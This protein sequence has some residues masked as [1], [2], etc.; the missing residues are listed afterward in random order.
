M[1]PFS[2][3][4]FR[5]GLLLVCWLV[6]GV[7]APVRAQFGGIDLI[8]S[9]FGWKAWKGTNEPVPAAPDWRLVDYD[10]FEWV[11]L[12]MPVGLDT[13]TVP[14]N[15]TLRDMRGKYT[16]LF[17][18]RPFVLAPGVAFDALRLDGFVLGGCVVSVNG[19]DVHR[20]RVPP[21]P[22]ALSGV[23]LPPNPDGGEWG[24]INVPVRP[25]V[26]RPGTNV[27]AIRLVNAALD[28]SSLYCSLTLYGE[29]DQ[30]PPWVQR[31]VPE[32]DNLVP[33]L[34][35]IEVV[36]GEG[37]AGVRAGDLLVNGV[38]ATNV[39]E[40]SDADYVFSFPPVPPGRVTVTFREGHAITDRSSSSNAFRAPPA[41][42]YFVDPDFGEQTL[43]ITEF[44]ADNEKGLK[45]EDG[46]RED[47]VEVRNLGREALQL[48][49]W[50]LGTD[51]RGT[52][53][54]LFPRQ[55]LGAGDYL[56]VF[57]S[58][59]NRTNPVA[60][61]HTGFKVPKSGGSLFLFK[62]DG[63]VSSGFTNYPVQLAD[64]SYGLVPGLTGLAGYFVTPTPGKKN[65]EGG[66]GFS[67]EVEFSRVSGTHTGTVGLVLQTTDPGA[68]IRYTLDQSEP[69][70][71]SLSYT[72]PMVLTN[73]AIVRA[74]AFSPGLLPGPVRT[75]AFFPVS[76]NLGNWTSTLPV[77]VINDFDGGRPPLGIRIPAYVQVFEPG[78]NGVTRLLDA[79]VLASRAAVASRG[80]STAG[81]AKVNLRLEFQ[82]EVGEDRKLPFAGLPA[83]ADW[84]LYG[85]S[86]FDPALIN[87]SFAHRL[88]RSIGRYAPRT[89]YVE[90]FLVTRGAQPL[91]NQHYMGVY[92]LEERIELGDERVDVAPVAPGAVQPP[93]VT[94]GYLFKIDR[95]GGDDGFIWTGRQQVL[96]VEPPGS[97]LSLAQNQWLQEYFNGFEEALY[98]GGY[99]DPVT[100]YRRY[101]DVPS[102]IDHHLLNVLLFNVDALRLSAYFHKPED[103]PLVFGPI[104]D[105]DRALRSTDGRD[106][107]PRVWR[108]RFQDLGTDFFN[109]TWWDRLFT[110]PDFFQEYIDRYEALRR[111]PFSVAALHGLVN[112]EVALV[113]EAQPRE[114]RRWGNRARGG[115]EKEIL[116]IKGWLS[117]RVAF[118]DGQ[119]VRPPA[120]VTEFDG[121]ALRLAFAPT[122]GAT[123]Y[124][125]LDG[126]DPRLPGGAVSPKAL[127]WPGLMTFQT[128]A[129]LTLRT[130]NPNHRGLTG[131]NNPP[132]RSLW[133]G[134]VRLPVVVRRP[135]MLLTEVHFNPAPQAGV[136]EEQELEFVELLNTSDSEFDLAGFR[137]SGGIAYTCPTGTVSR[138]PAGGRV[139]VAKDPT[140]FAA[141]HPAV[142][143]VLGPYEGQLSNDGDRIELVGR[144]GEPVQQL[145]YGDG[146]VPDADGGGHS[147]VPVYEGAGDAVLASAA[148]WHRSAFP[149]GSPGSL[150]PASIPDMAPGVQVLETGALIRFNGA[151]GRRYTV[152]ASQDPIVPGGWQRLG[153]V[154]APAGQARM[155]WRDLSAGEAWFYRVTSP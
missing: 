110:D 107:D 7:F 114:A 133:S 35:E 49:G 138:I 152:W 77:V 125:T 71:E 143:R 135:P 111:G 140:L 128:N 14:L 25:G 103:G 12:R 102:W 155:E 141:R 74:R 4:G 127:A 70:Q 20:F 119:F 89:R 31:V 75:E 50:G 96:V 116:D 38:G 132:I 37:V 121:R 80:S 24:G 22:L 142:E 48:E 57:A 53:R 123:T 79:P 78:T 3:P 136:E 16:T 9:N 33:R 126:S 73:M 32:A 105:F 28:D 106:L 151:L 87:N 61:L 8:G 113:I 27:L 59:K 148:G 108:S 101:I 118:I 65:A 130:W 83:D 122:N 67:S 44:L 68:E 62:P 149:R 84:V 19:E 43:R 11:S 154:T 26:L 90:V 112:A 94:G 13:F 5:P 95:A 17:L 54:W 36:F 21:E 72:G 58:G 153:T 129:L 134:V 93:A 41:W 29:R 30:E 34:G 85:P 139:V 82:D 91:D 52:G 109:Y 98:G 146:W 10:A 124:Y 64:R 150:D 51:L 69:Y 66:P 42:A 144:F 63:T 99:R 47:W 117:N 18:R 40:V 86:N 76:S 104:W 56:V 100:G 45:D 46:N 145:D 120:P 97:E 55:I 1:F 23:A 6:L 92:I 15:P 147:L 115:Y 131:P 81:N 137:L 60:P 88:S 39:V 2:G